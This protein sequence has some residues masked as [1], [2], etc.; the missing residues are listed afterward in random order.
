MRGGIIE[1]LTQASNYFNSAGGVLRLTTR[2]AIG[3]FVK[4]SFLANIANAVTRRDLTSVADVTDLA[5]AMGEI[6]SVKINRKYGPVGQTLDSFRK[7]GMDS[8]PEALS[9]L[10]GTQVAKGMEVDML[11]NAIRAGVTALK[12]AAAVNYDGSAGTMTASRLQYGVAKFG[13]KSGAIRAF[14]MHSKAYHDLVQ[15]Q[16]TPANAG[17]TATGAVVYGGT[18]ATL[19]RPVIVTDSTALMLDDSPDLYYTLGLTENGL[20]V[21]NTEEEQIVQELVTGKENLLV[22]LQGEWAYNLGVKGFK[23]NT[24]QGA[25]PT[26]AIVAT[27]A[28]WTASASS[29]KDYAG[30]CITT[31]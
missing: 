24:A 3:E 17:E 2:S 27:A 31:R 29:Y 19:G 7:V 15:H 23:Y 4:E 20:V 9:Y 22:R 28:S 11:N 25:N 21:E 14:I 13:D 30:V 26:D 10:I 8:S 16:L 5:Q 6:V 12:N 1:V 18:P